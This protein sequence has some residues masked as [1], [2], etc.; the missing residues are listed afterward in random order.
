MIVSGRLHTQIKGCTHLLT[1]AKSQ[2][3]KLFSAVKY[4]VLASKFVV[5]VYFENNISGGF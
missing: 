4:F 5:R 2:I 1:N 3:L